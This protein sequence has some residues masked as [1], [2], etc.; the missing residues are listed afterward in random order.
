[1]RANAGEPWLAA[2]TRITTLECE[3]CQEKSSEEQNPRKL[4][5]LTSHLGMLVPGPAGRQ[6]RP[7]ATLRCGLRTAPS[8]PANARSINGANPTQSTALAPQRTLS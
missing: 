7:R 5:P 4:A 2:G 6:L 8:A 1:L 3:Q